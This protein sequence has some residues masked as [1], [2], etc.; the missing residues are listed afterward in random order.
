MPVNSNS[1]IELLKS[2]LNNHPLQ[3]EN[4]EE[5]NKTLIN[6]ANK[7]HQNRFKFRGNIM[8]M[9][10]II[11]KIFQDMANDMIRQKRIREIEEKEMKQMV[12]QNSIPH[13]TKKDMKKSGIFEQRLKDKEDNFKK[14]MRGKRPNSIDFTD[15]IQDSPI[16]SNQVDLTMAQREAELSEIMRS[17]QKSKKAQSWVNGNRPPSQVQNL[18]IDHNSSLPVNVDTIPTKNNR[19]VRFQVAEIPNNETNNIH[20]SFFHKL[21]KK[22]VPPNENNKIIAQNQPILNNEGIN[23]LKAI[24]E[25]QIKILEQLKIMNDHFKLNLEKRSII[26]DIESRVEGTVKGYDAI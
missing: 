11:L 16:E 5:F 10:K 13:Q 17:Q 26:E 12:I 6:E 20:D 7:V 23:I 1:N 25:N 24:S 2:I 14:M 19:R 9:N 18:R 8:E 4:E 21:K 22:P 3:K 15:K